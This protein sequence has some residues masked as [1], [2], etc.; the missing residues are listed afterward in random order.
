[1]IGYSENA[2]ISKQMTGHSKKTVK[3]FSETENSKTKTGIEENLK[4]Q[5]PQTQGGDL[6]ELS[7]DEF[8][9][10]DFQMMGR[11]GHHQR[12]GFKR[13]PLEL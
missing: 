6:N 9:S 4:H 13:T 2:R 10:S 12:N 5:Y 7:P 1:M 11:S 3:W 8:L